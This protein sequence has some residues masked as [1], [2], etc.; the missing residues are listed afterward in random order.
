MSSYKFG[1]GVTFVMIAYFWFCGGEFKRS[2]GYGG[3][4][5]IPFSHRNLIVLIPRMSPMV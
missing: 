3:R 5:T 4:V 2:L 1:G